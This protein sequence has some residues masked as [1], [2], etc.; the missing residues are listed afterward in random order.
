MCDSIWTASERRPAAPDDHQITVGAV[1]GGSV[2]VGTGPARW[3]YRGRY[4]DADQQP[5]R[6]IRANHGQWRRQLYGAD[7]CTRRAMRF[8]SHRF[9]RRGQCCTRAHGP[10]A[11]VAPALGLTVTFPVDGEIIG[12]DSVRVSGTYQGAANIGIRVNGKTAQR[13]GS[14]FCAG[15]IPLIPGLNPLEISAIAPDGTTTTQ[16]LTVTS[17]GSNSLG[18]NADRD[19]GFAPLAVTFGVDNNTGKTLSELDYDFDNNGTVDFSTFDPA[20]VISH[21]YTA[22]GCYTVIVTATASDASTFVSSKTISVQD[23]NDA[24]GEVLGDFYRMLGNLRNNDI[25]AALTAFTATSLG[26]ISGAVR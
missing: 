9:Q 12:D 18:L 16:T 5:H 13:I 19:V 26:K 1:V 24:A 2:T 21:T 7:R 17:S 4:G 3:R 15:D 8:A 23:P 11:G 22:P 6:A 10:V 20:A 25:P 14:G